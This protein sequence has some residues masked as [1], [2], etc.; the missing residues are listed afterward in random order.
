MILTKFSIRILYCFVIIF[1]FFCRAML[2]RCAVSVRPSVTFVYSVDT[3][4]H[5]FQNIS[6]SH[7]SSFSIPSVMAIIRQGQP[8]GGVQCRCG[9]QKWRFLAII[10]LHRVLSTVRP[11][12]VIHLAVLDRGRLVTLV[13]GKRRRLFFTAGDDEV[14]TTL[15][16]RQQNKI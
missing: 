7:Y 4:K 8:N 11:P 15:P 12:R 14:V 10:W 2:C 6:E 3:I 1:I 16:R 13:D 5:I 9:R